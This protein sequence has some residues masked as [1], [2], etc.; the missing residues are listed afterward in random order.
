MITLITGMPGSGKSAAMMELMLSFAKES[1]PIFA[2]GIPDLKVTHMTL[3]P[4]DWNN[5]VPD[6]AVVFVDEVQR[7]WR[8]TAPGAKVPPE[9]E[10]FETHRHRGLDFVLVT[11]HPNL[12]HQNVRRLVGRHIHIRDNGYMGRW[13]YEWPEAT[14]PGTYKSAPIKTRYHLPKKVFSQYKSASLHVKPIRT[15]PPAFFVLGGA[16]LVGGGCVYMLYGSIGEK[17]G[18]KKPPPVAEAKAPARA[19]S[20][21]PA[22]KAP[23]STDAPARPVT[24]AQSEPAKPPAPVG[25]IAMVNRCQCFGADGLPMAMEWDLCQRS[26][27]DYSG[28]VPLAL[29]TD[30]RGARQAPAAASAAFEVAQAPQMRGFSAGDWRDRPQRQPLGMPA[31]GM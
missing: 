5:Q 6:G 24:M 20:E 13:W 2:D 7:V 12:L 16:L 17:L 9:I 14:D 27:R 28:I 11:Q 22:A 25:C 21:A 8:P 23:A 29:H 26:A 10:A 30:E 15:I 1:R 18:W 31:A 3:N 4:K 19:A